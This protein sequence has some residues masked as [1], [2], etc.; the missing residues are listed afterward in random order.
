MLWIDSVSLSTKKG[1][2]MKFIA[3]AMLSYS[4]IYPSIDIRKVVIWG[5]KLHSHTHSYIHNGF[6]RAF[7]AMGIPVYWFDNTD[8]VD[9]F[10]F[11]NSLF[12]TEGQVAGGMPVIK[13][14]FYILHNC[15]FSLPKYTP[16]RIN[17]NFLMLQIYHNG[18]K[19]YNYDIMQLEP[20]VYYSKIAR[21]I[22]MPWA[23]DLLP[24]EIDRNKQRIAIF[25][26][27]EPKIYWIGT[28][29]EG[30]FGNWNKLQPFINAAQSKGYSFASYLTSKS[31]EE[32]MELVQRSM[33]APAIQGEWQVEMGY[34][35]CRI[36]KNISYGAF[37]LTNSRTVHELF[38]KKIIYNSDTSAL[39]FEGIKKINE[40]DYLKQ[41]FELMDFVK[42][43]HTYLNRI[44]TLFKVISI[45]Q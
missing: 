34:I 27:R 25:S 12:I 8:N 13:D 29:G 32:N 17:L 18:C 11:K 22:Y 3:L 39:F 44:N 31:L 41:L 35:P 16:L 36:F 7:Q 28:V 37:G 14:A 1:E 20:F 23:T 33:L 4:L 15:D 26:R 19:N 40:P 5:H 30:V 43:H 6:Y 10:D 45:I 2:S 9:T 21:I 24:G 42:D 38:D